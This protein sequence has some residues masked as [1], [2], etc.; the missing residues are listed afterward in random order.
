MSKD[1]IPVSIAYA[2]TIFGAAI[3]LYVCQS[4][5]L[6]NALWADL[7]GTVIIL[8]LVDIIKIRVFMMPIGVLFPLTRSLL[9]RF[10]CFTGCRCDTSG[11]GLNSCLA[12]GH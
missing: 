5:F 9:A 6:L 12:V 4:G 2:V 7:V 11:Y 3:T 10:P 8:P 1:L